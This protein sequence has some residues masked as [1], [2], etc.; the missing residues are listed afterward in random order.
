MYPA[1]GNFEVLLCGVLPIL[2]HLLDLRHRERQSP[3]VFA[4]PGTR[5]GEMFLCSE[6]VRGKEVAAR[7]EEVKD[8]I[9]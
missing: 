2:R 4:V 9:G 5:T 7:I 1:G 6:A 8:H 3:V